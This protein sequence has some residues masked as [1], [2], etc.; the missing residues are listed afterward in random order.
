MGINIFIYSRYMITIKQAGV[1][2]V[3]EKQFTN[4]VKALMYASE[5]NIPRYQISWSYGDDYFSAFNW[6]EEPTESLSYYYTERCRQLREKYDYLILYY[7]GGSDSHNILA[8]FLKANL[9]VDEV[10]TSFPI[11]FYDKKQKANKSRATSQMQNEWYYVAK[12]DLQMLQHLSPKTK[13]TVHDYTSSILDFKINEDSWL[14][15]SG[16]SLQ[17]SIAQ[18]I[19]RM[20]LPHMIDLYEKKKVAHIYGVDKPRVFT[21][22]GEWYFAFLDVV[23]ALQAP[24]NPQ[25]NKHEYINVEKFYWAPESANMLIKQAHTVK[26]F[27]QTNHNL[28]FLARYDAMTYQHRTMVEE[29]IR[30]IIY[31]YWRTD[32]YQVSKPQS[33]WMLECDD[34][35]F[36]Q[37]ISSRALGKW[38]EGYDY[39]LNTINS[40][41][42]SINNET[43]V[44]DAFCGFWSKWHKLS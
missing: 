10:V 27:Y 2:T 35:L 41:F 7:S 19:E 22:D 26:K 25:E 29:I 20:Y 31:P 38:K 4:K 11:E 36:N 13:I 23:T 5:H 37:G 44:A 33:V 8:H 40:E 32:T 15:E 17:P 43:N 16:E 18:Y 39:I 1:Y 34:I 42:I 3:G 9:L 14:M 6:Q 30:S 24:I 12:K 28:Q 21:H